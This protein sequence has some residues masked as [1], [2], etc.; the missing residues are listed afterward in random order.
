MSGPDEEETEE[1]ELIDDDTDG[2]VHDYSDGT[3]NHTHWKSCEDEVDNSGTFPRAETPD[4][5]P[6]DP[7][8]RHSKVATTIGKASK[9]TR[10]LEEKWMELLT[11]NES[12]TCDVMHLQ[13]EVDGVKST[14]R[15]VSSEFKD[16]CSVILAELQE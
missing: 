11:V 1:V 14:L 12:I 3:L 8:T 4:S 10:K 16:S 13:E 2:H 7:S 5:G 9:R 6:S 15:S